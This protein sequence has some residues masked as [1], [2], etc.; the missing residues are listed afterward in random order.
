VLKISALTEIIL[1][2]AACLKS[3]DGAMLTIT[4]K[5]DFNLA[6]PFVASYLKRKL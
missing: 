2:Y 1:L 4:T 3:L 5:S 6:T